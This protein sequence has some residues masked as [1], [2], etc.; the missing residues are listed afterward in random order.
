MDRSRFVCLAL[1]VPLIGGCASAFTSPSPEARQ[2]LAPTGKLRV[3]INLANPVLAK[4]DPSTGNV[5]GI[6]MDLGRMLANRLGTEFVPVLYPNPGALLEGWGESRRRRG[7]RELTQ[8]LAA[9]AAGDGVEAQKHARKAEQ[10]FESVQKDHGKIKLADK[11]L[12]DLAAGELFALR[13]LLVGKPAPDIF[14]R[15][16]GLLAISPA[17]CWVI[18]D[19]RPGVA[20]GLA[21][22]MRVIAIT[23]TH[24][25][26]ELRAATHVVSTYRQIETLLL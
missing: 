8:G 2:A 5:S 26:E 10:L 21:A 18:E 23:N 13:H 4:R 24:P 6:T 14:L 22:G 20:A 17:D 19:S 12:S 3:G 9:V 15:A 11:T 7:Y 16:A 25:A 1:L